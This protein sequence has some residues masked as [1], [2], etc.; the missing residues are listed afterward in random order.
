MLNRRNELKDLLKTQ[1][2][3]FFR[4]KNE[5]KTNSL[6]SAKSAKK[7]AQGIGN[8]EHGTENGQ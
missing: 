5:L 7:R 2:L 8:K 4:A 1:D 3:A 6:L